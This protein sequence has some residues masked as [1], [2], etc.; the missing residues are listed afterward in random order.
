MVRRELRQKYKG[1]ALGVAWY[2]I[3]PLVLMGAYWLMFNV[4]LDVANIPDYPL[5]LLGGLVVW[6]FFA[7]ALLAAAP[8][9]V[10]N[11]PLVRKA[12]FPRETIPASVVTVQL[13]TFLAMLVLLLPVALLVRDSSTRRCCSCRSS[14][15]SC[16]SG[17]RAGVLVAVLHA[18]FRDVEPIL[19]AALLPWFFL[20]PIFLPV[21][22]FPGIGDH[23]LI[24]DLLEWVNPVAPFVESTADV[25]C[26][27]TAP[28]AAPP[29][30]TS[31]APALLALA[32]RRA[33]LPPDG[34]RAGGGAV[35]GLAPRRDRARARHALVHVVPSAA[36]TLKELV[37]SLGAAHGRRRV[38]ALRDVRLHVAPG[39]TVGIVGRN[40]A[41]KTSTLRCWPGSCRSTRA[42]R[43]AAGAS[44]RCSSSA[45]GFGRDFTGRE[46]I[47]LNGA[48]HGFTRE[49]IEERIDEI[50][51][52]SE[53][54]EFIDVPV[55]AY[56]SGMFLRLG[57][58]IAAHLDADVLL[59]DEVL[60]VGDEAFQRKCQKR[61]AEQME[62]GRRSCSSRTTR[63]RSSA[64]ATASSCSTAGARRSTGRSPRGS[65]TITGC[66]ARR[67]ARRSRCA[68]RPRAR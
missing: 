60:A 53:L 21:E 49:E 16:S 37:L 46:N 59:I 8:S 1:S 11:A 12:R 39:E 56:S 50:V 18:F 17:A 25:L 41:G 3:N 5:F 4:L 64:C 19:A 47:F 67:P 9:L 42:G 28:D 36:R 40:G 52:F 24:G 58:A 55:K 66:S 15:C 62:R 65:S 13:V 27:A 63:R 33:R 68:L 57:F 10:L 23:E 34:A 26:A 2:L 48:L 20:S 61:I 54:G 7:Q 6:V 51:E 45:P 32:A 43:S 22:D 35:S 30:S 29:A 31:R 14:R 44:S 38:H